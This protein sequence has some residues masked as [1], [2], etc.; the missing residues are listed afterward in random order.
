M[1][2][3]VI[4]FLLI[5]S[6]SF[7]QDLDFLDYNNGYKQF[8]FGLNPEQIA[9]IEKYPNW[10][11]DY[12]KS[13]NII[14]YSYNGSNSYKIFNSDIDYIQLNFHKNKLYYITIKVL[15]KLDDNFE[16][17]NYLKKE[18]YI[19]FG[20]ITKTHAEVS[21]NFI[22]GEI[23]DGKKVTLELGVY[24]SENADECYINI[25][26]NVLLLDQRKGQF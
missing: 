22:T 26:S 14:P 19:L 18:L 8:K 21:K 2:K 25:Y 5:T 9:N 17:Y 3:I 13:N 4:L 16:E 1:K 10:D 24:K 12:Y 11:D 20:K 7:S 6:I 23:W 15:I